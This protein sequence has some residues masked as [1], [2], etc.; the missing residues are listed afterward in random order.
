MGAKAKIALFVAVFCLIA[1]V[2]FAANATAP[3]K[4]PNVSLDTPTINALPEKR[5]VESA[6]YMRANHMV[7]LEQWRD[8]AVRSGDLTYVNSRGERFE[9]SLHE[10]CL[11][12]HS[13]PDEFCTACHSYSG[14]SLY[15]EDCHNMTDTGLQGK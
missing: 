10:T 3:A 1:A 14:V 11:S 9:K 5:C 7:M 6:E 4:D 13:N 2:P 8:D 12:C 15:C